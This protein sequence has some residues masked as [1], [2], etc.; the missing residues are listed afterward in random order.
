MEN[1]LYKKIFQIFMKIL[2]VR[3][4]RLYS[5]VFSDL[6]RHPIEILTI[7]G[8]ILEAGFSTEV[9]DFEIEPPEEKIFIKKLANFS[10][11][12]VLFY[13]NTQGIS[14]SHFFASLVK[15][16][17]PSA[18]TVICGN[19]VSALPERTLQEFPYFEI[20]IIGEVEAVLLEICSK[21]EKKQSYFEVAGTV[22]KQNLKVTVN[23]PQDFFENLN[24]LP[25]P[26]RDLI[27]INRY[28][29]RPVYG[30]SQNPVTSTSLI[31][32]RGCSKLDIFGA[33]NGIISKKTRFR[34]AQNIYREVLEAQGRY[35]FNYFSILDNTAILKKDRFLQICE[36]LKK[37]GVFW[38][39]KAPF[40]FLDKEI[41]ET[42]SDSGCLKL[43]VEIPAGSARIMEYSGK[44]IDP[45]NLLEII[46]IK[47]ESN[48]YLHAFFLIGSH[49]SETREEMEKT[50]QLAEK[51]EPDQISVFYSVPYPGTYLSDL[52]KKEKHI[53]EENWAEFGFYNNKPVWETNTV[54]KEILIKRKML[55]YRT[56]YLN[57]NF[58]K[59][60]FKKY[61]T[62]KEFLSGINSVYQ[63]Y[64]HLKELKKL[65]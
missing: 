47:K 45:E 31:S 12:I 22:I 1:N 51:I 52:F 46:N 56:F 7:A 36:F 9:L 19:H 33:E 62:G 20:G 29:S 54:S 42:I 38:D 41:M 6:P 44:M 2:L 5:P 15:K 25:F 58:I 34:S 64:N 50:I 65:T 63:I 57:K 4:P 40:L 14:S 18:I 30:I 49:P 60:V 35:G 16:E 17:I 3:P 37:A 8:Y 11:D 28:H 43:S 55:F 48:I 26:A 21:L 23:P 13:S 24:H 61:R 59:S 27:D 32:S 39:I 53:K 10:P